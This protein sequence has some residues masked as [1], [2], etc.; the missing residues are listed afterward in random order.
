MRRYFVKVGVVFFATNALLHAPTIM[1]NRQLLLLR[2]GANRNSNTHQ[3]LWSLRQQYQQQCH[4]EI[5]TK[6]DL[7]QTLSSMM[8]MMSPTNITR[9]EDFSRDD[10]DLLLIPCRYTFLDFGANIGD[11]LGKFIDAGLDPCPEKGI[12][13]NPHLDLN[14]DRS[15]NYEQTKAVVVQFHERENVLVRSS[16]TILNQQQHRKSDS[17]GPEDYCY[18]GVEGN[19]QFTERLQ[20][21]ER[22]ILQQGHNSSSS[23]TRPVQHVHFLTETVGAGQ[24]GPTVLYLDTVNTDQNFW[25]SS[26]LAGHRDVKRSATK[27]STTEAVLQKAPVQGITL[28]TLLKQ[29]VLPVAGGHVMIKMDIEGGE[30]AVLEEAYESGIMC[31]YH[32]AGVAI[33]LLLETHRPKDIGAKDFDL[34]HWRHI[35]KTLTEDCGVI[36]QKGRDAGR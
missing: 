21:L 25:G 27:T 34:Q 24:D 14:I 13:K 16:R 35:K 4:D 33:H 10:T 11:S 2:K 29:T 32:Q 22:R 8:T 6:E 12:T 9:H 5:S 17:V 3:D 18:Y 20:R 28:T 19:P 23:S 36:L 30:Y 7:M 15:N 31:E 26:L 1:T